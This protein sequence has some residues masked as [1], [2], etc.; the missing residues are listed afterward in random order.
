MYSRS[1][2]VWKM[3]TAQRSGQHAVSSGKRRVYATVPLP[4]KTALLQQAWSSVTTTLAKAPRA[5]KQGD[6]S[7]IAPK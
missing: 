2:G 4:I 7:T 3:Q 1:D 5:P 6:Q